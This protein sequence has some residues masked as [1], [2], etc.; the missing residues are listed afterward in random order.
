MKF[1]EFCIQNSYLKILAVGLGDIFA[2][3]YSSSTALIDI[4]GG[5]V[6]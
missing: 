1:V 6:Y 2:N 4:C 3:L 5:Y